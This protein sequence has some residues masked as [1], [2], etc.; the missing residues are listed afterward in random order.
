GKRKMNTAVCA[1]FYDTG[2]ALGSETAPAGTKVR[3]K[4]RYTGWPAEEA[5]ALFKASKIYDTPMLDPQHH[6]IFADEWPKLTFSKFVPM[7]E[8]GIDGR[9]ACLTGHKQRPAYA[10]DKNAS[11]GSGL[12]KRPG[13]D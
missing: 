13:P 6:Y 2:V 8:A 11:A 1:A 10:L 5:E 4:Y 3:V 12:A 9:H 7:S